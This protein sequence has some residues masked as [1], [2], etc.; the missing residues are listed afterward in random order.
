MSFN[1]ISKKSFLITT[2]TMNEDAVAIL[3][4]VKHLFKY[5]IKLSLNGL[6]AIIIMLFIYF[7]ADGIRRMMY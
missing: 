6:W 3:K 7:L 5:L 1:A 2:L 4:E